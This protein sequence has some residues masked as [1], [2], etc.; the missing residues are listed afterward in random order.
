[1]AFTL[2][3]AYGTPVAYSEDDNHIYL[4]GGIPVA[5]LAGGSVYA[6]SGIHLGRFENGWITD[7]NGR[8]VFFTESALEGPT[9]P[10]KKMKPLKGVKGI[11]PMKSVKQMKPMKPMKRQKW[12]DLSGEQFFHRR[13]DA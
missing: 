8:V 11:K 1:M 12:S 10:M 7:N 9:K 2:Y 6:F 5:Y 3:D 13:T 4:F